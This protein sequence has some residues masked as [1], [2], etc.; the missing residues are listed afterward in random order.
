MM[1]L[2]LMELVRILVHVQQD[3]LVRTALLTLMTAIL[4]LV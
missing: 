1:V 3:T 2:V 4:I